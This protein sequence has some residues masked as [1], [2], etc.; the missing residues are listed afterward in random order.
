MDSHE[1]SFRSMTDDSRRDVVAVFEQHLRYVERDVEGKLRTIFHLVCRQLQ[2]RGR[3]RAF[4]QEQMQVERKVRQVLEPNGHVAE[5]RHRNGH[6]R[7]G[8]GSLIVF[9]LPFN[10]GPKPRRQTVQA[11]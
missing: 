3:A 5:D 2:S 6:L 11:L 1:Q 9:A 10:L 7:L 4:A 8:Q